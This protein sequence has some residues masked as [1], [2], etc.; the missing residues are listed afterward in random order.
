MTAQIPEILIHRGQKLSLCEQPLYPYLARIPKSRRPA[1]ASTTT[2]CHR[3]Y[4][5]TWEIREDQLY[6]VG[7]EGLMRTPEGFVEACVETALPW[8][9]GALAA[10]WFSGRVRCPEG[11]LVTYV[12]HA[13][14][15]TYERDRIFEFD[16]GDWSRN[17]SYAIHP[18]R[19]SIA[20]TGM[21]DE[22]ASIACVRGIRTSFQ[23]PLGKA[24]SMKPTRSG[25]VPRSAS[26]TMKVM[27]SGEPFF[28]PH[29]D[30]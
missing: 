16:M 13:Y 4:V 17:A 9:K 8:V 12:H 6:L 19:S 20:S 7:I 2:A 21:G 25:A 15:S 29:G 14:A 11:R 30:R 5:G 28:I 24:T 23:I 3:G 10:K 1:F 18:N 22:P 27:S 26:R